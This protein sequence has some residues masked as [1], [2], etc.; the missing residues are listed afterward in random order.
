MREFS[1]VSV[2]TV[3]YHVKVG[4]SDREHVKFALVA[5]YCKDCGLY[6]SKV[7]DSSD[8]AIRLLEKS[9]F[10]GSSFFTSPLRRATISI[11][12][13]YRLILDDSFAT[14]EKQHQERRGSFNFKCL[15]DPRFYARNFPRK[16][17]KTPAFPT[18]KY[19]KSGNT[20]D[21][22]SFLIG[23]AIVAI[24]FLIAAYLDGV[25]IYNI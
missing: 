19:L 5:E 7:S 17:V 21:F 15:V 24:I 13:L 22:D 14:F 3:V 1:H 12:E 2:D 11:S 6:F 18:R 4:T 9:L 8:R 20:A 25:Y 23:S 10:P 16:K